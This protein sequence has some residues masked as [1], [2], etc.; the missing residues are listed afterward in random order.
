M[1]AAILYSLPAVIAQLWFDLME[2]KLSNWSIYSNSDKKK[3]GFAI[4]KTVSLK[5]I[6]FY[7]TRI[8]V[9]NWNELSIQ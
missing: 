5:I 8:L 7:R 6:I 9:I 2:I 4:S 1:V 3:S